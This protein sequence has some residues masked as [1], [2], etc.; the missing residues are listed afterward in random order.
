MCPQADGVSLAGAQGSGVRVRPEPWA[1]CQKPQTF[2]AW[3]LNEM[4]VLLKRRWSQ[5]HLLLTGDKNSL[6]ILK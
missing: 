5:I 2:D 6:R 4:S 3:K 1:L